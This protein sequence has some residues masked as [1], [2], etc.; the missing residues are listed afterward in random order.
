[1]RELLLLVLLGCGCASNKSSR[2]TSAEALK[3]VMKRPRPD[4]VFASNNV[5]VSEWQLKGAL[6]DSYV[7]APHETQSL[8]AAPFLEAATAK[9]FTAS[10]PL[11]CI[12]RETAAFVAAKGGFPT[13]GL[14]DF[15]EARCGVASSVHVNSLSGDA[16]ASFTDAQ[17]LEQWK[18]DLIKLAHSVGPGSRAGVGFVRDNGKAVVIVAQARDETTLDA[19]PMKQADD[20]F[21]WI[22]G[23]TKRRAD[24][25]SGTVNHGRTGSA[26]CVNTQT[27]AAPAF[28]LKCP[29]AK[30]D[31]WAW[32]SLSAHEKG[33]V[34]GFE[35]VRVLVRPS[36]SEAR[37]YRAPGLVAE[38][39]GA[40]L[41]DF[42]NQLNAIRTQVGAA[43]L[44]VSEPQSADLKELTPFFFQAMSAKDD[45]SEDQLALGVMAGWRVEQEIMHGTF[46]AWAVEGST[47]SELLAAM[48]DTPSYRRALLSPRA[49]VLAAGLLTEGQTMGGVVSTYELV[50]APK[51]PDT[52]NDILT[53]LN[54]QRA[55]NGKKPIQWVLMPS[56]LEATYSEAVAKRQYDSDEAM[57]RFM[58][59]A[60]DITRRRVRGYKLTVFDLNDFDWPADVLSRDALDVMFFVT[61]ERVQGDPWGRYVMIL[62]I[63]EG[64]SQPEA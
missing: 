55:R 42:A 25:V 5:E 27:R 2:F 21:V 6:P 35:V 51:W 20:G 57:E 22:R 17:L 45:A 61:T 4:K 38:T 40:T 64:G 13:R 32:L 34:L 48:L 30:E 19:L 53:A 59:Q 60:S 8:F 37:T 36:G 63:L 28:E 7:E 58:N 26:E 29:V 24:S 54:G 15:I 41:Q 18:P 56:N 47:A 9:G 11:A 52:A 16:P 23:E 39:P 46:A 49:G 3:E 44:T 1:M 12:A 14:S 31:E 43:P 50:Q 10:E 62:L 33:R